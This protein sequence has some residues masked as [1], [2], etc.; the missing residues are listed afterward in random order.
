MDVVV[1][2]GERSRSQLAIQLS[3]TNAERRPLGKLKFHQFHLSLHILPSVMKAGA[4]TIEVTLVTA[5]RLLI[6]EDERRIA[7]HLQKGLSENGFTVDVAYDGFEGLELARAGTYAVIVLDI[8]LPHRNGWTI[9]D[10]LRR[11]G[12]MT[13]V[14]FVTALDRVED[15]V[16]GLE[17]GAD[18]YLV[19]PYSFSELLA[20]IRTILRRG[21]AM[22]EEVLRI[23]DLEIDTRRY[24][25]TRGGHN[26]QLTRR[27][28][29][30]LSYLARSAGEVVSRTRIVEQV[31]DINFDT[32]SNI[33]EATMRRLRAKVDDPFEKPL[34][35]N[36]RGIGYVLE[37][38]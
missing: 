16:K 14:L 32:G 38:R 24:K 29:L 23:A 20:R 5:M 6:I 27:E 26:L 36:V 34:I 11:A 2:R 31:W 15:R 17:M 22:Q 35:H 8:L 3:H 10:E 30:L 1:H 7:A 25:V 18:D 37:S 9:L 28:F 33:V 12:V 19:K 21:P 13:P 4:D